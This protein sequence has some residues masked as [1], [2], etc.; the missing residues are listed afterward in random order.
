MYHPRLGRRSACAPP[1]WSG[2]RKL[3]QRSGPRA[4]SPCYPGLPSRGNRLRAKLQAFSSCCFWSIT[5]PE[6]VQLLQSSKLGSAVA[7]FFLTK[8]AA[9]HHLD[10]EFLVPRARLPG[11]DGTFSNRKV[12]PKNFG[13]LRGGWT[14]HQW[15]LNCLNMA[16]HVVQHRLNMAFG[17][18]DMSAT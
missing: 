17:P 15:W 3:C 12:G 18:K 14:C 11:A 16:E 1:R 2:P 5:D 4:S 13:K 9:L 10:I 7:F 6:T 8:A